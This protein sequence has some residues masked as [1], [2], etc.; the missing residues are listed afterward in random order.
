[1]ELGKP[2]GSRGIQLGDAGSACLQQPGSRTL[3]ST[4]CQRHLRPRITGSIGG[5]HPSQQF[6]ICSKGRYRRSTS[7]AQGSQHCP[8]FCNRK[9]RASVVQDLE[10]GDQGIVIRTAF[11]RER[12][13]AGGRQD[14]QL[15]G[16]TASQPQTAQPGGCQHH[17]IQVTRSHPGQAGVDIAPDVDENQVR[18]QGPQLCHTPR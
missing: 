12:T 8:L 15:L 7:A 16:D 5:I 2:G 4:G 1:M 13:L 9:S 17:C 14:G 6:P 18:A 10:G 3:P 11:H